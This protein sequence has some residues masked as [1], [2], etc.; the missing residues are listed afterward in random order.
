MNSKKKWVASF[1]RLLDDHEKNRL[2]D[3]EREFSNWVKNS[4]PKFD[5]YENIQLLSFQRSNRILAA[6]VEFDHS[7]PL[8]PALV[9]T[10]ENWV[11]VQVKLLRNATKF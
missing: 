4:L 8:Y 10:L 5:E 3:Y 1:E 2:S 11:V 7:E 9:P 6:D